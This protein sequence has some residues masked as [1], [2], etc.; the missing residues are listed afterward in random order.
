M[1]SALCHH[2]VLVSPCL[3]IVN[4]IVI[5]HIME[6]RKS[7]KV[8]A[9][10]RKAH[11]DYS[12]ED[13]FEAG[14]A[15]HGT[16]VKALREGRVNLKESF[17]RIDREEVILHNCH[18]NEYS[19]GNIMNHNPLRTR[20]LLLHRKEI[21]RLIDETQRKGLT[22]IPLKV[23]F[24]DR[25]LA[26]LQLAVAKGKRQYDR[27]ETIKKREDEREIARVMKEERRGR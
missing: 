26:K 25:G 15:L 14:I 5:L 27:R 17:A 7:V 23:Y 10:N 6:S 8:V 20:K 1:S 22:L 3:R 9:T 24:N 4:F 16:E 18:I 21:R 11:Y 12:I 2:L 19:H 13:T